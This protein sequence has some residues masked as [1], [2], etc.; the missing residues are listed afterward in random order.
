MP[1][2]RAL[3]RARQFFGPRDRSEDGWNERS[4]YILRAGGETLEAWS[5]YELV[6]VIECALAAGDRLDGVYVL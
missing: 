4:T 2:G 6:E 1:E 5:P 3:L